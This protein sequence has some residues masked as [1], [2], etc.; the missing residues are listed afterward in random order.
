M[1]H[2]LHEKSSVLFLLALIMGIGVCEHIL[3]IGLQANIGPHIEILQVLQGSLELVSEEISID[4]YPAVDLYLKRFDEIPKI[5]L[6]PGLLDWGLD[7][8][9]LY[10]D[11]L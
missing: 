1:L 11:L 5:Y 4:L 10:L 7:L 6:N 2:D 3:G 9:D 8:G